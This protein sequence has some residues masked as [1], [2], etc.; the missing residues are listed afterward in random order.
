M[1][2]GV[3]DEAYITLDTTTPNTVSKPTQWEFKTIMDSKFQGD[4]DGGSIGAHGFHVTKI[5]LYRSVYGTGKWEAVGIFDYDEDYNVYDYSD[6]YTQN[7]VV[8]QYA[9]VPVANEIQGDKLLSDTVESSYEGI[10][11]TD[12]DENRRL[13]YDISLGEVSYN[14]NSAINQPISGEFPIVTFGKSRYRSGSLST[15]PLSRSTVEMHGSGIDKFAEE[16][17]R[18]RWLDFLNNGRAKV[19]RMDSGVLM[20]I[21]TQNT[22]VQHKEEDAL[23][24]LASIQFDYV[25]IGDIEW[26]TMLKSGLIP[27]NAYAHNF[28]YDD[29]GDIING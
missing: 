27:M 14:T 26:N 21:V 15:L 1:H 4:L 8:Y 28:T 19:L 3:Y 20:L 23:R 11:I 29:N 25:E 16:V 17:N 22:V 24:A 7:G 5:M 12:K 6:R 18:R 2:E 9:I 10:F 13:E